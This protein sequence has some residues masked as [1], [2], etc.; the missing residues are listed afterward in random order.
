[1]VSRLLTALSN[2]KLTIGV[3]AESEGA[4]N[5]RWRLPESKSVAFALVLT[6]F[7]RLI[8]LRVVNKNTMFTAEDL[9]PGS[10][11]SF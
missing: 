11:V 5:E 4:H 1:M 6:D 3:G 8:L 7:Y 2:N 10:T 9:K